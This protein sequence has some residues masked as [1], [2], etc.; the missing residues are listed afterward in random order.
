MNP[1]ITFIIILSMLL[2]SLGP[3]QLSS[4]D[5]AA[6]S[7]SAIAQNMQADATQTPTA[8]WPYPPPG[9]TSTIEPTSTEIAE[10]TGT[11]TPTAQATSTPEPNQPTPTASPTPDTPVDLHCQP[12][13]E[14][15]TLKVDPEPAI[16]LPGKPIVLSWKICG[17]SQIKDVNAQLVFNVPE[18]VTPKDKSLERQITPERTLTIS[19]KPGE[20]KITWLVSDTAPLPFK[21][22]MDLL[23]NGEVK[24]EQSILINAGKYQTQKS[25]NSHIDAEGG[26]IQIDV[27]ADAASEDLALDVRLPS[28]H[29]MPA[30]SLTG[31]PV[32]IIAAGK[33]TGTNV[34]KFQ[35]PI[36]IKIKY[37]KERIFG[38]NEGDLMVFYFNEDY[39]DWYPLE[40]TVDLETQTLIVLSDH[41]TVFDYKAASWQKYTPPT[42]DSF[43]VSDFTGAGMYNYDF[44]VPPASGNLA[45]KLQL[46]Y[47]SQ[48][49]DEALSAYTQ[50]SWVGLGWSLDTGAITRNMHGT[51]APN[52]EKPNPEDDDTFSISAGGISGTL[53][54]VGSNGDGTTTYNTADQSFAKVIWNNGNTWTVYTKEGSVYTFGGAWLNNGNNATDHYYAST[55][56]SYGCST[57]RD[58]IWR[59]SLRSVKDTH[60]NELTFGYYTENKSGCSNQIAVYPDWI[61]Y[62]NHL[63][64]IQ[65]SREMRY[66]YQH[67]WTMSSNRVLY[68]I[69]RLHEIKVLARTSITDN[70]WPTVLRRYTFSYDPPDTSRTYF[71]IYPTLQWD[72]DGNRGRKTSTLFQVQE[73]G[74]NDTPQKPIKFNYEDNLHLTMVDNGQGGI[75]TMQYEKFTFFDDVGDNE[76]SFIATLDSDPTNKTRNE[77]YFW[78]SS[79]TGSVGCSDSLNKMGVLEIRPASTSTAAI[80]MSMPDPGATGYWYSAS[81]ESVNK[82]GN[83][84]RLVYHAKAIPDDTTFGEDKTQIRLGVWDRSSGGQ[85]LYASD[86]NAPDGIY[87]KEIGETYD[88]VEKSV[89]YPINFN[90]YN[91]GPFIECSK[92]CRVN[93]FQMALHRTYYRVKAKTIQDFARNKSAADYATTYYDYDNPS[94]NT[95]YTSESVSLVTGGVE[96]NFTCPTTGSN[97]LLYTCQMAEFRG[98]SM[99]QIVQVVQD[100]VDENDERKLATVNWYY[101]NDNLK[102]RSYRS[103]TMQ[104]DLYDNWSGGMG[105]WTTSSDSY[106]VSNTSN[107]ILGRDFDTNLLLSFSNTI[108]AANITNW[109]KITRKDSLPTGKAVIAQIRLDD[110]LPN[111]S[112]DPNPTPNPKAKAVLQVSDTEYFGVQLDKSTDK[113]TI[114]VNGASTQD[115]ITNI[116]TDKWYVVMLIA[117][118]AHGNLVRIWQLDKPENAGEGIANLVPSGALYF[119]AQVN[120]GSLWMSAYTEGTIYQENSA[121][122]GSQIVYL[123]GAGNADAAPV[124]RTD[125]QGQYLSEAPLRNF[126]DLGVTWSY[127]TRTENR[128][129]DGHASWTGSDILIEYQPSDQNGLQFGNPTRKTYQEWNGTQFTNHHASRTQFWPNKTAS[130]YIAGLPGREITLDCNLT[131]DFTGTSI[132]AETLYFY[133]Q[134]TSNTSSPIKGDLT[135]KLVRAEKE[136]ETTKYS[137]SSFT[138]TANG[139]P[140]KTIAFKTYTTTTPL[141]TIDT[142]LSGG[143]V[144]VTRKF[145]DPDPVTGA[146]YNTYVTRETVYTLYDPND[147]NAQG[148]TTYT[149]YD[150]N[151]GLPTV[152]K[153]PN[154]NMWGQAYDGLGRTIAVCAPGDWNG[155]TCVSGSGASTLD[156]TYT[157]YASSSN[158]FHVQLTQKQDSQRNINIVRYYSG[159]GLLLQEQ[160]LGVDVWVTNANITKNLVTDYEYDNVGRLIHQTKPYEYTGAVYSF[161]TQHF[162]NTRSIVTTTYDILS[163]VKSIKSPNGV[164]EQDISYD[165]LTTSKI[166]ANDNQTKTTKNV[167]GNIVAVEGPSDS[168][169]QLVGPGLAYQ[170]DK[171]GNLRYATVGSGQTAYTTEIRY[172]KSNRK[173][174]MNDPDLGI[175]TYDYD[176][177]GN[178]ACQ[179]DAKNNSI[180]LVYDKFNRLDGK[181]YLGVNSCS[182][183]TTEITDFSGYDIQFH[184][185]GEAFTYRNVNYGG[186]PGMLGQRTGMVDPSGVTLWSYDW[187]GRKTHESRKIIDLADN[188]TYL[189]TYHTYWSYYPDDSIR[190]IVYPNQETV[191]FSYHAGGAFDQSYSMQDDTDTY[192]YYVKGSGY[193][194]TGRLISRTLHENLLNSTYTYNLWNQAGQGGRLGRIVTQRIGGSEVF[195]DLNYTYDSAG[196]IVSLQSN[197][198]AASIYSLTFQYDKLNRLDLVTGAYNEDPTYE[199][200]T[201]NILS[202]NGITYTYDTAHKHA[203]TTT[204]DGRSFEYD[205]NGSMKTRNV[206]EGSYTLEYDAESRLTRIS[207]IGGTITARYVYD[208]DGNRAISIVGTI[209]IRTV[210]IGDNFEA[211]I[212]PSDISPIN[213][214]KDNTLKT[215]YCDYH[216]SNR[217][218][219]PIVMQEGDFA[220]TITQ[221]PDYYSH[222]NKPSGGIKWRTYYY[223]AGQRVATRETTSSVIGDPY[224]LLTDHLGSTTV[225]VDKNGQKFAELFYKAWGE[226]DTTRSI[227]TTPTLRRYTGQYQAD[228]GLM[229]YGARFYDPSLGRFIQADTVTPGLDNLFAWDR[230]AY[231]NNSPINLNDPT[232]H[233]P[234]CITAAAGAVIGGLAGLGGYA[235]YAAVSG[236]EFNTSHALIATAGGAA[237]GLLIGTGIGLSQGLGLA[238]A[239]TTAVTTATTVGGVAEGANAACGGDMCADESQKAVQVVQ[240]ALP[241][242]ENTIQTVAQDGLGGLSRAAQYGINSYNN[243][244]NQIAGTGLEA[245]HIIEKRFAGALGFTQSQANRFASVVVTPEEHQI[246]TN[247]WRNS[248]GYG[249]G[250][251]ARPG[252]IWQAA[253]FVYRGYPALLEAA[254]HTILGQ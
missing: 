15:V 205:A 133:D 130:A 195:Q 65:F 57:T 117:D 36:T 90:A 115:L 156:I 228:T 207:I 208:G 178:L 101:Q 155:T 78:A 245:H 104:R 221:G 176:G 38:G 72:P 71:S 210:Y 94:P 152:V 246:F 227:G 40:T 116:Q 112:T 242:A 241:A 113:A 51:D 24:G 79:N 120:S 70:T 103:L 159:I 118:A 87:Q 177:A 60:G 198:N 219:L 69:S 244:R 10:P 240:E 106:V 139:N 136:G 171:L 252:E 27:P 254:Q 127:P 140:E 151:F 215:N 235:L 134:Q 107:A 73:F 41:L 22:V 25:N 226:I 191:N 109:A 84:I 185:D 74:L 30:V 33:D 190:Q 225:T 251:I 32:E 88:T 46:S 7:K 77:C 43:K 52:T 220:Q 206:P 209:P 239:T 213:T 211:E 83:R 119:S 129:Y 173:V 1:T 61:E 204:T 28:F 193:D 93:Y 158:P 80:R 23:V 250:S 144:S 154:G 172:D 222:P 2:S 217:F 196:N 42:V 153:D 62:P 224:Y 230:Y 142:A 20:D 44:W 138:Y 45:P 19:T 168:N 131:C 95:A 243:L 54:P 111:L 108:D 17:Y 145:Y 81:P 110:S 11:T 58:L 16:Y 18:G 75:V 186:E 231:A 96:N 175:Q 29:K 26:K 97:S 5:L 203:V 180:K 121:L 6:L 249:N 122:Y 188:Y 86:P 34:K 21:L 98:H 200:S 170:Y 76:R 114:I 181:D 146:T 201:G 3:V 161:Q 174:W 232:G 35:K 234:L 102:G 202:R 64:R 12:N 125:Q 160:T 163:R 49:I 9:E 184:Y 66:D 135:T 192:H 218:F 233:C 63:Y 212:S 148:Q 165:Q 82:P 164:K 14:L 48:I 55:N 105:N 89:D 53:L 162:D 100:G 216:C 179:K 169:N 143:G 194:S 248:I 189:G 236:K 4:S 182:P 214:L 47:N 253:Q 59:W 50:G 166:D 128:N 223:A 183:S 91:T 187:R 39:Q 8:D 199:A 92:N 68:G 197:A 167:W 237:A 99:T 147:A 37:D 247:L 126:K 137:Q 124:T 56:K 141:S 13:N 238:A 229:F 157:D 31:Y 150:Y 123:S 149:T 85:N 132:L 67:S